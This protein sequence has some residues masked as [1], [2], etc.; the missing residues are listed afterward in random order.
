MG[1]PSNF[2]IFMLKVKDPTDL[3]E[4]QA[5]GMKLHILEQGKDNNKNVLELIEANKNVISIPTS[6]EDLMIVT[7][8]FAGLGSILFGRN[9]SLPTSLKQLCLEMEM[10]RLLLKGKVKTDPS[11]IAKLMYAVDNR[12]QLWF[13]YLRRASDRK[14]VNDSILDF[15]VIV[16]EV[17]LDQFRVVLPAT[18]TTS[19]TKEGDDQ[20]QPSVKRQKKGKENRPIKDGDNRK[21]SNNDIP[22]EFCLLENENYRANFTNKHIQDQPKWNDECKMCPRWFTHG[23]CFKDCRN[24]ASHVSSSEVPADKK[25]A[26]VEY[27]DLCRRS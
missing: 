13:G 23:N 24:S 10:N 15:P 22:K 25:A 19:R 20:Q 12:V 4:Q 1:T 5:R 26:F 3:N 7:R 21:V 16:N 9:S 17:V 6:V 11:L 18:F 14:D 2:S 27:M 8:A